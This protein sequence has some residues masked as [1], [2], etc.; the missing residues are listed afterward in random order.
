MK[1]WLTRTLSG[2]SAADAESGRVLGKF[3]LGTTFES[4]VST[5]KARSTAWNRRYWLLMSRLAENVTQVNIRELGDDGPPVM[6]PVQDSEGVHTALKF[7]CGHCQKY[8]VESG[9][10]THIVRVPKSISFD[11]MTP[12]EW[13]A[14]WPRIL[15]GVHQRIL[16]DVDCSLIED[17]LARLAS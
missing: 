5:R 2:C 15:D 1:I 16:P 12:D 14:Y 17:D 10:E 3:P 13:A 6:F 7:I 4:E 11:Q 8:T 9:G